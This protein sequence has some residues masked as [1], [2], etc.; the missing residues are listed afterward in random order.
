MARILTKAVLPA[1]AVALLLSLARPVSAECRLCGCMSWFHPPQPSLPIASPSFGYNKTVWQTWPAAC[2]AAQPALSAHPV[3]VD[4]PTA[5]T[6]SGPDE[7]AH[8]RPNTSG[9]LLQ[10]TPLETKLTSTPSADSADSP[11]HPIRTTMT[12]AR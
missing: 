8:A 10:L 12:P 2:S 7:F 5:K 1:L 3:G 6:T 11:Y 9:G 4:G